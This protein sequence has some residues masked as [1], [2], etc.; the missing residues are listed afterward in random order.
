MNLEFNLKGNVK[1]VVDNLA[2]ALLP[3]KKN[4]SQEQIKH[5]LRNPQKYM[6]KPDLTI[7]EKKILAYNITISYPYQI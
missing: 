2:K 7:N 3:N 4:L 1:K 6:H 5:I